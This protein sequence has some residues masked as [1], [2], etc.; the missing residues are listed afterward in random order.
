M[1]TLF[2]REDC[3][4]R[5]PSPM[6][7]DSQC[8]V[9]FIRWGSPP[10]FA[11]PCPTPTHQSGKPQSRHS[12]TPRLLCPFSL[13]HV[14]RQL[15]NPASHHLDTPLLTD[16]FVA[17]KH[18]TLTQHRNA[19]VSNRV[20][21]VQARTSDFT[22]FLLSFQAPCGFFKRPGTSNH[23]SGSVS[24]SQFTEAGF[25]LANGHRDRH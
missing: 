13:H 9:T 4:L 14:L 12:T 21:Q 23:R 7:G 2:S 18:A 10:S 5:L 1:L 24:G 15:T 3:I 6:P 17:H 8:T 20:L 19:A 11:S 25:P 16:R 22:G